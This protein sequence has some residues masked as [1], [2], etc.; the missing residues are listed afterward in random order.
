MRLIALSGLVV[1]APLA[2]WS[3]LAGQDVEVWG[4]VS[5]GP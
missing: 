1:L 5:F 3:F 4:G 2:T